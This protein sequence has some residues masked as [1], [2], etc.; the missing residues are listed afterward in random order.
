MS[1]DW[2]YCEDNGNDLDY[3]VFEHV[4]LTTSLFLIVL[5]QGKLEL[6]FSLLMRFK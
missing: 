2:G 3:N 4:H 5:I 6:I 1:D